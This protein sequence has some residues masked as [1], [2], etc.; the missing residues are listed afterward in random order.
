MGA[1]YL[2]H[3]DVVAVIGDVCLKRWS[4]GSLR[5]DIP[6]VAGAVHV[7]FPFPFAHNYGQCATATALLSGPRL[8]VSRGGLDRAAFT[9]LVDDPNLEFHEAALGPWHEEECW[10]V[11]FD[12]TRVVYLAKKKVLSVWSA[13]EQLCELELGSVA[14]V[15]L[16]HLIKDRLVG[17]VNGRLYIWTLPLSLQDPPGKRQPGP[18]YHGWRRQVLHFCLSGTD[19][20][21]VALASLGSDRS[22]C[23][24]EGPLDSLIFKRRVDLSFARFHLDLPYFLRILSDDVVVFNDDLGVH[25]VDL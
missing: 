7:T 13:Q 6:P 18:H 24:F 16:L 3:S 9:T 21:H 14:S 11:A 10:P 22:L 15:G 23:F 2:S 25:V 8:L 4:L 20:S 5:P 12:G 17:I 1:I 19:L